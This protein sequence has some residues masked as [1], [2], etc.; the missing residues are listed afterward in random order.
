M[1]AG[2]DQEQHAERFPEFE[3][4]R[5]QLARLHA[6][7][8]TPLRAVWSRL[9]ELTVQ[10]LN[11]DRIGVWILVDE[12]RVLRCRYLLERSD[13]QVFQGAVLRVEDFPHYF[14]ALKERR[15]LAADDA[16]SSPLTL[17]LRSAYLAPLGITSMLDAPIYVEGRVVGVVCHEHMGP[18]RTWRAS[19]CEFAGAVADN[20]ARIYG[21]HERLHAQTALQ[22]YQRHLM[23]LHR[24]EAV[25]RVAAGIAHDF[26]SIIGVALGFAELLRR[27]PQLPSQADSY[28]NR[29]VEAL[30]RGRQLTQQ[31]TSFGKEDAAAPRVLDVPKL[32]D[33][34][35]NMFRVLIGN[36]I[37]FL[38]SHDRHIS[39]VF[40]DPTQLERSLLNLVL[41]ARDAMPAGG[42]LAIRVGDEIIEDEDGE[43]ATVVAISVSDTG[44]GM[45]S[46]TRGNALKPFFSTKGEEGTGLGLAIVDQIV[47]RAGGS[48]RI[49]SEPGH[50]TTVHLYLPRIASAVQ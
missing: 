43:R 25:G 15:T 38:V 13:Q 11:I 34:L 26:R 48:I 32:V 47:S 37:R 41:N 40:M 23:E 46:E 12:E 20:I 14:Q 42:E 33:S 29:I 30:D 28:A 22:T 10:T 49:D 2:H 19:E 3:D 50:G 4:A 18:A 44:V 27:V 17:E 39:R 36:A 7:V 35:A 21:E 5:L 16:Q 6:A 8:D 31:I 9:A 24:M 45:D 1:T